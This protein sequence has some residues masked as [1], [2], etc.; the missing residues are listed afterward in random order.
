MQTVFSPKT[1]VLRFNQLT[2]ETDKSEQQGM[3]FLYAGAMLALRNP[4][5]HELMQDDPEQAIEYLS[6]L[7]MLAK[8]LDRA[9]RV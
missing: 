7:S 2:T 9:E 4:R 8:A 1:P 3:M 5:A 6:L